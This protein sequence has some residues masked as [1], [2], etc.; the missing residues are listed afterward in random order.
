MP[1]T[2]LLIVA[3]VVVIFFMMKKAGQIS[4]A[5]ALAYLKQGAMVIDVRSPG[6]YRS[7]HL[8]SAINIP[9]DDLETSLPRRIKEKQQVLLLHCLSGIRS[10]V[11]QRKLKALG[12]TQAFNVGSYGRAES[13]LKQAN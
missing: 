9:L 3:V 13:I 1:W 11:A 10:G 12:Y 8:P 7:G 5:H 2:Y 6:E 4:S